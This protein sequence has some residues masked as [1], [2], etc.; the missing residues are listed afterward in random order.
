ME[1]EVFEKKKEEEFPNVEQMLNLV[2]R[3]KLDED[4]P[5]EELSMYQKLFDNYWRFLVTKCAGHSYWGPSKRN[6]LLMSTGSLDEDNKDAPPLVTASDEAFIA[7]LWENCYKKWLYKEECKRKNVEPDEKHDS[8]KTPYTN[9]KSGKKDFGGWNA[10][11][12]KRYD[13]LCGQIE[14]NRKKQAK[15]IKGVEEDALERIQKA[16]KVTE[17]EVQRK[18]KKPMKSSEGFDEDET[19]DEND[20]SAW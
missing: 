15:Y 13:E 20:Y 11:G 6:H 9:A 1:E 18:K 7:V 19:D 2:L 16:E 14:E 10:D 12:I 4:T 3:D 5:E 17:K 8:M